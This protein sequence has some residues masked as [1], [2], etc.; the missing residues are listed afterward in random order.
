M[1]RFELV[2]LNEIKAKIPKNQ[3]EV[4]EDYEEYGWVEILWDNKLEE[5]AFAGAPEPEDATL[6]RDYRK[7]VAL[8]N[9]V[10]EEKNA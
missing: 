5:V 9:E 3:F 7:L 6:S 1:S 2:E 8:L 10:D 4:L